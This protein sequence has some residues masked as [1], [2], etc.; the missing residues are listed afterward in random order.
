M[1]WLIKCKIKLLNLQY[2][3]ASGHKF[4]LHNRP[5]LFWRVVFRNRTGCLCVTAQSAQLTSYWLLQGP[6]RPNMGLFWDLGFSPRLISN[7]FV[8][9]V[10]AKHSI[11]TGEGSRTVGHLLTIEAIFDWWIMHHLY[12]ILI[13]DFLFVSDNIQ[14]WSGATFNCW[15]DKY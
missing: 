6:K 7:S 15:V 8:T 5:C 10:S 3:D 9:D 14:P 12:S 1:G 11:T 2:F 13:H 4:I